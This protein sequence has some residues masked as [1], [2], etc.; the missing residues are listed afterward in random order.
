MIMKR[1]IKPDRL[2]LFL[3]LSIACLVSFNPEVLKQILSHNSSEIKQFQPIEKIVHFPNEFESGLSDSIYGYD[4]NFDLFYSVD[5]GDHFKSFDVLKIKDVSAN[6]IH[7]HQLSYRSKP[8]DGSQPVLPSLL[9]KGKHKTDPIY[10]KTKQ[11]T[12][13][14]KHFHTLPILSLIVAEHDLISDSDGMM[15]LGQDAWFDSGF[16]KPFWERNAN[17]KR[18]GESSKKKVLVDYIVNQEVVF[19]TMCDIQVSGNATRSF[20]QKSFKI[21]ANQAYSG[22]TFEFPFFKKKGLKSYQSIVVRNSGND[23]TKTLFADLLMHTLAKKAK[24]LVQK[25]HP[26]IVYLNGNYWGIYNLRERIDTYFIAESEKVKL[27]E[28]TLLEGAYADLKDGLVSDQTEFIDLVNGLVDLKKVGDEDLE[29]VKGKVKIKSFIDYIILETYYANGDWLHNNVIWYKAGGKKWQWI[30]ND[31]DYGLTYLGKEQVEAN[32]FQYLNTSKAI[33]AK[34]FRTLLKNSKFKKQFKKRANKLM[35][36]LFNDERIEKAYLKYFEQIQNELP[37][38]V[39]RWRGNFTFEI[40]LDNC[41]QNL[42]FLKDRRAI[43]LK[44]IEAL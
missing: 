11:V 27:E 41:Q 39:K 6:V 32:L 21:K 1:L 35:E 10:L 7:R 19:H 25:G 34:F 38:Q 43:Y 30:L 29:K 31:L 4:P 33:N 5:G 17:Y 3:V 15:V 37:L 28:I 16:K 20:P 36:E 23:N 18:R 8:V 42:N 24:V 12:Y 26:V 44:Q 13:S 9:I 14:G 2:L 22:S 40:W